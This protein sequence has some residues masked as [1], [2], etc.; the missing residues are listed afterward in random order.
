MKS[1]APTTPTIVITKPIDEEIT[2]DEKP[3]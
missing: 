3:G 1:V 2:T